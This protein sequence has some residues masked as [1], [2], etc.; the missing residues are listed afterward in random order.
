MHQTNSIGL[1]ALDIENLSDRVK[2]LNNRRF[3]CIKQNLGG[4]I[5]KDARRTQFCPLENFP[6]NQKPKI[7]KC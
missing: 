7:A 3:L 5:L 2:A 6:I 1:V 4:T